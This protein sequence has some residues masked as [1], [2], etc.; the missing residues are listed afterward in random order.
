MAKNDFMEL[1]ETESCGEELEWKWDSEDCVFRAEC[2]SSLK[3][4]T[5][6]PTEGTLD[7]EEGAF[8][9]GMLAEMDDE[10]EEDGYYDLTT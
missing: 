9:E 6:T 10:S 7:E 1:Y 3:I 2:K 8:S 5:L 4:F